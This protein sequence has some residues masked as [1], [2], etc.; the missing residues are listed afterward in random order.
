MDTHIGIGYSQ[1]LD[2][3]TASQE[4]V[5]RARMALRSSTA[6]L[7]LIFHT[8]HHNTTT[9][10]HT[11]YS[12]F[13]DAKIIGCS[14]AG[15][16]L[17]DDI[18]THGIGVLAVS[19]DEIQFGVGS[20]VGIS[21]SNIRLAGSD[22]ARNLINDYG[23]ASR[24]ACLFFIDGRIADTSPMLKS[25]GCANASGLNHNSGPGSSGRKATPGT[26]FTRRYGTIPPVLLN[27]GSS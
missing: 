27:S 15:V 3:N 1:H 23:L 25:S 12:E 20:T 10:I 19:S 14:S 16:I 18:L 11:A 22:L 8:I 17:S 6:D 21:P 2:T 7:V 4:A 5:H 24:S 13:P 9:I 26:E